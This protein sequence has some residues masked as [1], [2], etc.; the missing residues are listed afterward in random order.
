MP[1]IFNWEITSDLFFGTVSSVFSPNMFKNRTEC[2]PFSFVLCLRF[3]CPKLQN[4]KRN[5][6]LF[7]P[8]KIVFDL[9]FCTV[10]SVFS[11][12]MFKKQDGMPAFFTW[13]MLVFGLK[14][15]TFSHFLRSGG[16]PRGHLSKRDANHLQKLSNSSISGLPFGVNFHVF[17]H[18]KFHR[19]SGGHFFTHFLILVSPGPPK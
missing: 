11:P 3:S 16:T 9:F 19:F 1:A 13:K 6:R 18:L 5:A 7:R 12:N 17:W 14:M 10:S 2:W 8:K 15:D 4:T